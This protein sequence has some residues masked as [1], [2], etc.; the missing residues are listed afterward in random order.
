M[1]KTT[2]VY[3]PFGQNSAANLIH[4]LTIY[5]LDVVLLVTA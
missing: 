4:P 2:S 3:T 5:Y 1:F